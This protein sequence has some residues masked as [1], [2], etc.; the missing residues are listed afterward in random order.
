MTNESVCAAVCP[1]NAAG[2]Q[3][4]RRR[5]SICVSKLSDLQQLRIDVCR[6]DVA[7]L[8]QPEDRGLPSGRILAVLRDVDEL[9]HAFGLRSLRQREHRGLTYLVVVRLGP[10]V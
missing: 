10:L 2:K 4:T 3:S 7:R 9:R 1:A 5:R 6:A 8:S